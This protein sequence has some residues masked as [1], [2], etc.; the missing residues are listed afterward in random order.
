MRP[1]FDKI[2]AE[3]F[4]KHLVAA[5]ARKLNL[6][7]GAYVPKGAKLTVQA[8][9]DGIPLTGVQTRHLGRNRRSVKEFEDADTLVALLDVKAV[10]ELG[11]DDGVAVALGDLDI[12]EV[13][14]FAGEFGIPGE[15][16]HKVT[17]KGGLATFGNRAD[18]HF[19]RNVPQADVLALP[20]GKL[21]DQAV[22]VRKIWMLALADGATASLLAAL[23]CLTIGLFHGVYSLSRLNNDMNHGTTMRNHHKGACPL[24][25]GFRR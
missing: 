9:L 1:F 25:G 8:A 2:L 15:Q 7:Q 22:E 5:L 12:V 23:A 17:R 4:G 18:D 3:H 20:A 13:G 16:R 19:E 24:C 21:G 11:D 6:V 14:P 10:H